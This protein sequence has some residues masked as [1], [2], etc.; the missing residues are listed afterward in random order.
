M[1]LVAQATVEFASGEVA[2]AKFA[3]VRGVTLIDL[4]EG[5]VVFLDSIVAELESFAVVH[6]RGS[7]GTAVGVD[8]NA[9]FPCGRLVVG[10]QETAANAGAID[11]VHVERAVAGRGVDA[12]GNPSAEG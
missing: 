7:D 10:D 5:K 11:E 8:A 4:L 9:E 2:D 3:E 12:T 1:G 6:G